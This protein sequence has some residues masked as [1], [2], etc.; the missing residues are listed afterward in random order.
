MNAIGIG[1]DINGLI[2]KLWFTKWTNSAE[3]GLWISIKHANRINIL[4]ILKWDLYFFIRNASLIKAIRFK[5]SGIRSIFKYIRETG[6]K[7][8][9]NGEKSLA[10]KE[11]LFYIAIVGVPNKVFLFLFQWLGVRKCFLIAMYIYI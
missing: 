4:F 10:Q 5:L 8:T 6:K 1:L 11:D 2:M 9:T 7:T 3:S